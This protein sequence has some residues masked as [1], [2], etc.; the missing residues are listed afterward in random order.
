VPA[1]GTPEHA[2]RS[3]GR[4][5]NV[6]LASIDIDPQICFGKPRVK[7]TRIWVGLI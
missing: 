3:P 6:L 5:V 7:G 4:V 1:Q 2:A